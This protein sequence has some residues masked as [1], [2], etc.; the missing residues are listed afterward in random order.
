M[1]T[2]KRPKYYVLKNF[3]SLVYATAV[4]NRN[5]FSSRVTECVFMGYVEK[6]WLIRCL[7]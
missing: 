6:K 5:K 3:G 2:G 1:I 7:I 4:N